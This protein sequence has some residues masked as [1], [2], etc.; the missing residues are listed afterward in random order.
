MREKLRR[1]S[2]RSLWILPIVLALYL[3]VMGVDFAWYR[4]HVPVRFR[5]SNW[6]GHWQ[7]H[8]FLGLRGRLL[9]LLPDPLPEGVD[10]KAEALVYY[11]VYSV[12]R[13]G[14][15]VRMDFTGHFR[16]ETPSSGGQTT[17]AIPSGSGMM[18]FKAIVGNQVVEYAAL[19]DDSRTSVV[20]GYL[21][22]APDDFGH[23]TL[24]RH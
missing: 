15:F 8:R 6:K 20:G 9:A 13:T 17:N 3:T 12:W 4:S 5:D 23:F 10:F 7:T 18:K 16:P 11:P 22:R 1:W 19:L 24:T 2:K 21:S 14:Q